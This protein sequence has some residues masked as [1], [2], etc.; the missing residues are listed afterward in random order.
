MTP[1]EAAAGPG[2]FEALNAFFDRILVVTLARAKDRQARLRERLAGLRYELLLGFDKAQLD[3]AALARDGVYDPARARAVDR[4]G[5][6]MKPGEVGCSLSHRKI[7]ADAVREGWGRVLVLE[8]DA[9]PHVEAMAGAAEALGELPEGWEL[10]Y[11]GWENF[12]TVTLRD[13][14][15]QAA[16]VGMAAARLMKWT[17]S[18]ILRFHPRP[19]S[20]HL[21]TAGLHHCTHAYAFT[22]A[23]ARKLLE[24]Q[25]P[26]AYVA[27]QLLIHLILS[28]Q[29]RAF[30][31][32]PQLFGQER[33][34]MTA[35]ELKSE[36]FVTQR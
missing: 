20:P 32:E 15:K 28:G 31:M 14:L 2:R 12:E 4:H 21:K 17:P 22:T 27:D 33:H 1:G 36:S 3:F 6:E 10:V 35:D 5:R 8:D 25:T 7:Y 34:A 9:V 30:V 18:Q 29:L 13:R 26:T 24:A 16:Y 19:F 11:L 23:G